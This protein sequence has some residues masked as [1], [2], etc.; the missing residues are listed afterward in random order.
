GR[1]G[2]GGGFWWCRGRESVSKAKAGS[3]FWGPSE[4]NDATRLP[5]PL[6]PPM[7]L[8]VG[9]QTSRSELRAL[10]GEPH[11]VE[12]DPTRTCGGEEDSWAYALP[13]GH[14]VIVIVDATTGS[15]YVGSD[16]PDLEPALRLL[17]LEPEDSRLMRPAE[18]F[19]LC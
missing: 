14:R 16:P 15:A 5:M 18:P 19:R 6:D 12:T 8:V 2:G 10:L 13:S 1:D 11:F 4:K 7:W 9:W 3:W 17:N